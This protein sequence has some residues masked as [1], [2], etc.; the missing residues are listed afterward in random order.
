MR[1]T[2]PDNRYSL[3]RLFRFLVWYVAALGLLLFVLPAAG[4]QLERHYDALSSTAKFFSVLGM[5]G[6]IA[7]WQALRL[8]DCR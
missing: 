6:A 3:R 4:L 8:G 1:T 7:V 2:M 5:V